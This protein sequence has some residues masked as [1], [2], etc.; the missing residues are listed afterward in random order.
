MRGEA[1]HLAAGLRGGGGRGR[2]ASLIR[3]E[4]A[5]LSTTQHKPLTY[6]VHWLMH[7]H[8]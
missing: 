4:Q 7:V 8:V 3:N 5:K 6:V 2:A 1:G